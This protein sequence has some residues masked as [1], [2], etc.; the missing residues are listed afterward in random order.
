MLWRVSF[1]PVNTPANL[2]IKIV[3][4]IKYFVN[5]NRK[6]FYLGAGS[7][8]LSRKTQRGRVKDYAPQTG[9]H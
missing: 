7:G 1:L 8:S 2:P 6:Y 5:I 4:T 3:D 9:D